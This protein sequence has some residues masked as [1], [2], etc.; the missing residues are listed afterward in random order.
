MRENGWEAVK[1]SIKKGKDG[2]KQEKNEE[3]IF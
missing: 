2:N 3:K 1:L